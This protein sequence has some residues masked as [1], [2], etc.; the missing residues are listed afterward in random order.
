MLILKFGNF[1]IEKKKKDFT[2]IFKKYVDID[3]LLVSSKISFGEKNYKHFI[4]YLY[5][6][7]KV[8]PLHIILSKTRT[9]VKSYGRRTN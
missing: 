1:K 9:F 7:H 8:K 2:T 3:K 5:K 6:D 4:G